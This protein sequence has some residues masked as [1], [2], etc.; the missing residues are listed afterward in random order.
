MEIYWHVDNIYSKSCLLWIFSQQIFYN[1]SNTFLY[2]S[3]H[4]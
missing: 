2:A 1:K 4:S 3:K